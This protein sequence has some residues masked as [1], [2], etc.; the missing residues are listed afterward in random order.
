MLACRSHLEVLVPVI[1]FAVFCWCGEVLSIPVHTA[2]TSKVPGITVHDD[3][4]LA[5]KHIHNKTHNKVRLRHIVCEDLM[6]QLDTAEIV[7]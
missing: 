2:S 6:T 4:V 5:C 3:L 7:E 1:E